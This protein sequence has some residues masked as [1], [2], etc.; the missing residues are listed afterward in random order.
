M[1]W[2]APEENESE[3]FD[4]ENLWV[5]LVEA[6]ESS[7]ESN[8]LRRW[9][10]ETVREIVLGMTG[11]DNFEKLLMAKV[12]TLRKEHQTQ[13]N[14]YGE[15]KV[16]WRLAD[17]CLLADE[18]L[19][20]LR[21]KVVPSWGVSENMFWTEY[22][23]VI[24]AEI[25]NHVDNSSTGNRSEPKC[26][27]SELESLA[28]PV[29]ADMG[30]VVLGRKKIKYAKNGMEGLLACSKEFGNTAPLKGARISCSLPVTSHTGVLIE[31]LSQLGA[32]VR[33]CS[34]DIRSIQDHAAAAMAATGPVFAWKGESL[35]EYW[36]CVYQ[37][38]SWENSEGPTMILDHTGDLI[39]LVHEGMKAEA[40]FKKDGSFPNPNT[41][42]D[43][44]LKILFSLLQNTIK[45]DPT[46]FTS[47]ALGI[48][49]VSEGDIT[50]VYRLHQMVKDGTLLFPAINITESLTK[51]KFATKYG[52]RHSLPDGVMRATD[53][54]IAGKRVLICGFGDVGKGC[55]E[56]MLAAGA[57]VFVSEIDPIC[58]L[59][60]VMD[61]M[62]VKPLD[63]LVGDID[64]VI[65]ATGN[66]GIVTASHMAKMKN[67]CIIGNMG[68]FGD[69]IDLAGLSKVPGITEKMI[70]PGCHRWKFPDGHGVIILAQGHPLNLTC[71]TGHPS[72][73]MS[74]IYTNQLLAQIELW[75]TRRNATNKGNYSNQIHCMPK[76]LDEKVA[77]LHVDQMGGHLTE[78]SNEQ[79][80]YIGVPV[81]GPYK[82]NTYRY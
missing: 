61:G 57:R 56:T 44:T 16:N 4:E 82:P 43:P 13:K 10:K 64:I 14:I 77:R 17:M 48:F 19:G 79:A 30:D 2:S 68:N 23:D 31:I 54:M 53:V 72:V 67:N 29:V 62:N 71:S 37:C 33:L 80:E 46:K 8:V 63:D 38:L 41:T 49:G 27:L 22:F 42:K 78:L 32:A 45:K 12:L 36:W 15:S 21:F 76:N 50:G 69:E 74:C 58:A 39:L 70:K 26:S 66:K 9:N 7:L 59:Q 65:T 20:T 60:A 81:P 55:A 6:C 51:T 35:E 3:D 24:M 25:R 1:I 28:H 52:A 18:H 5:E 11:T 73:V 75:N 40:Q 34:S 47:M